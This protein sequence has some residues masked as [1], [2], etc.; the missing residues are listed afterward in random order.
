MKLFMQR[1]TVSKYTV[2]SGS[3]PCHTCKEKVT[4]L[5]LYLDTKELT[6]LC[7][8]RH[9]STVSLETKKTKK[10]YEREIRD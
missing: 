9:L 1:F 2:Y 4:S 7:S 8:S 6:W 10:D 5:R 3:F